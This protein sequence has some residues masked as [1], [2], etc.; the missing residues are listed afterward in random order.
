MNTQY[1]SDNNL[2]NIYWRKNKYVGHLN[3]EAETLRGRYKEDEISRKKY[4]V[5]LV[6][7]DKSLALINDQERQDWD[8]AVQ[9]DQRNG[10]CIKR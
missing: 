3:K 6:A 10:E 8:Q 7:S 1:Y 9:G 2:I 5:L 4:E